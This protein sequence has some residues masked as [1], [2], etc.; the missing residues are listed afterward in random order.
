MRYYTRINT[1]YTY[2][3]RTVTNVPNN[4]D[5]DIC[6]SMPERSLGGSRYF[7]TFVDDCTW[8]VWAYSLRSKDEALTVFSRWLAEVENRTGQ[9]VKTLWSDKGREYTS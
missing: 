7:I 1:L 3:I 2:G 8:N 5:S 9:R 6:S 4:L